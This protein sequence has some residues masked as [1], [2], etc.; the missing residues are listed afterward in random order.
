MQVQTSAISN[1]LAVSRNLSANKS[2]ETKHKVMET[3]NY[4]L[5]KSMQ[6][7]REINPLHVKRLTASM[8]ENYLFSP[9][10]V[11]EKMEIIDGQHRLAA[12]SS[13]SLPIY[14]IVIE[15][16]GLREVQILNVNSKT[17][18]IDDFLSGYCDMNIEDYKRYKWFLEKYKFGH[19]VTMAMLLG[20]RERSNEAG[21]VFN[22]GEFK[23]ESLEKAVDFAEKIYRIEPYFEEFKRREFIFSIMSLMNNPE[24]NFDEFLRKLSLQPTKLKV[25]A[26]YKQY[27]DMIE[28]IYNHKRINKVNLRF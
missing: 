20:L 9:L 5:F 19:N 3:R 16:Y 17:W 13:L 8:S 11:N 18:K 10:I 12:A 2:T 22:Q 24:F 1:G 15:G 6:G 28:E 7:N 27:K 23:I 4:E 26:T 25:G 14:Y 21:K